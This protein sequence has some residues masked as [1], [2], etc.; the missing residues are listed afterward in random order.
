MDSGEA[1]ESALQCIFDILCI[2]GL[3]HFEQKPTDKRKSSQ[4]IPNSSI[5]SNT[6]SKTL[7]SNLEDSDMEMD[8]DNDRTIINPDG[9][10]VLCSDSDE[11][12]EEEEEEGESFIGLFTDL[13]EKNLNSEMDSIKLITAQGIAKLFIL[14]IP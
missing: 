8:F 7:F 5:S 1:Q 10:E 12:E 6:K 2:H 14:G 9:N 11:H 4:S 13:L 3:S